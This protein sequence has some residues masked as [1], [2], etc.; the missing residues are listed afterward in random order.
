MPWVQKK[1]S[2]TN[3]FDWIAVFHIISATEKILLNKLKENK[4]I[5]IHI[6][7]PRIVADTHLELQR[8][9][10]L[11]RHFSLLLT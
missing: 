10:Y 3:G 2:Y 11:W 8:I 4:I 5:S 7:T 1:P 9:L 6:H